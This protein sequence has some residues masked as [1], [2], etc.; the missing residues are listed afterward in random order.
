MF[1]SN[2]SQGPEPQSTVKNREINLQLG[3][4]DAPVRFTCIFL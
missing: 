1:R 3:T 4:N 2:K